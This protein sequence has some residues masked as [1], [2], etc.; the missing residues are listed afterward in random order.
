MDTP[1]ATDHRT[2]DYW[3]ARGDRAIAAS[4][5]HS[6]ALLVVRQECLRLRRETL[7][8][9]A[10]HFQKRDTESLHRLARRAAEYYRVHRRLLRLAKRLGQ[11]S[12]G[13]LRLSGS[14]RSDDATY[15]W[16]SAFHYRVH[17]PTALCLTT[18]NRSLDTS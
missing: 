17:Q 5:L 10:T 14:W 3:K 16:P 18:R 12:T 2:Y 8:I 7:H 13:T 9:H 4:L 15:R 6:G 1:N 11:L